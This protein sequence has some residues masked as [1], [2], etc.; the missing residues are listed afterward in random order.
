MKEIFKIQIPVFCD[1][2]EGEEALVYNHDGSIMF[3]FP[4]S[5]FIGL[6]KGHKKIYVRAQIINTKFV[7]EHELLPEQ[8]W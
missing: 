6:M 7:V 8:D 5:E 4:A 3:Q 2:V 1:E